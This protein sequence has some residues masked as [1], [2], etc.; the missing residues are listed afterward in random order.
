M[1]VYVVIS[2]QA[3]YEDGVKVL[4]VFK[5]WQQAVDKGMQES[6]ICKDDAKWGDYWYDVE[7][8]DLV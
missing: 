7:E 2:G 5:T 3:T 4:G 1:K 8:H 6:I